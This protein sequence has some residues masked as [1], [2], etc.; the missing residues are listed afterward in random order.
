MADLVDNQVNANGIQ[1]RANVGRLTIQLRSLKGQLT[2]EINF[3]YKKITHFR[4]LLASTQQRTPILMVEY[5]RGILECHARCKT[6]YDRVEKGFTDLQDLET[7]TWEGDN[8]ELDE[9]LT[10]MDTESEACF[11]QLSEVQHS[12]DDLF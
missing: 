3:C 1:T 5:A 9:Y 4:N 11:K 7:E 10:K 6:K 2:R 8:E 12:N